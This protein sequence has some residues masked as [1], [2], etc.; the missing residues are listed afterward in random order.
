MRL[1]ELLMRIILRLDALADCA[2]A[3]KPARRE[4]VRNVQ[5]T[6]DALDRI[7]SAHPAK[8]E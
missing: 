6:L 4:A 7:Y 3:L 1:Q 8:P 2:E 5:A